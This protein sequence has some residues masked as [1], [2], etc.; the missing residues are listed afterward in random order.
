[1]EFFIRLHPAVQ[2]L[3]LGLFTWGV[4]TLGAAVVLLFKR[5]S[6]KVSDVMLGFSAGVMT[7]AVFWSLLNPS[8]EISQE[9][10]QNAW[11]TAAAGFL[12]GGAFL[13]LINF[14]ASRILDKRE[15][16]KAALA[17]DA[18]KA[19]LSRRSLLLTL[20]V[21]M[22]NIP[23]GLAVGVAIGSAAAGLSSVSLLGAVMV[24]VGI[25]IQD[26]PEGAAVSLPLMADGLPRGKSFLT[27]MLSGA[28]EPVFAVIGALLVIAVRSLLPFALAFAAGAMIY[29]VV[30]EL[31]PD[32]QNGKNAVPATLGLLL[33]FALMMILDIAL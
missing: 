11:L 16:A 31:I 2:A 12:S 32:S 9:L 33:G 23:E 4:T 6:K 8:I 29:V 21:T 20:A 19:R 10:G 5:F 26:F 7:A 30:R 13:I 15:N 17:A 22:H 18:P 28:V 27:G 3:I 25:G 14:F 1:M 24:A